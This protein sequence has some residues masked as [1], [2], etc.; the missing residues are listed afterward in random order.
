MSEKRRL[1]YGKIAIFV[2]TLFIVWSIQ[3]LIIRPVF[4][5]QLNDL[6]FEMIDSGTKILVWICPTIWMLKR[7]EKE[8]WVD[9]KEMFTNKPSWAITLCYLLFIGIIA[10]SVAIA[11]GEGLR[12]REDFTLIMLIA[13]VLVAGITEELVFRGFIL[14]SLLKKMNKIFAMAIDAVLFA[15]IHYPI[16]IYLGFGLTTI[17]INS[18]FSIFFSITLSHS[19]LKTKN[20]LVPVAMHMFYNFI[21]TIFV[22]FTV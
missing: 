6:W 1:T 13:P 2:L 7:F 17:L 14:N 11:S 20:L 5:N 21:V 22:T 3:R 12:I 16:W 18:V 10:F 4:L 19:L 8:V 9:L 15:F